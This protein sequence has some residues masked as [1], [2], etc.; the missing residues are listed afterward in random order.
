MLHV[1]NNYRVCVYITAFFWSCILLLEFRRKF[2]IWDSRSIPFVLTLIASEILRRAI[3][4][5]YILR[6]RKVTLV[7]RLMETRIA[8]GFRRWIFESRGHARLLLRLLRDVILV[9]EYGFWRRLRWIQRLTDEGSPLAIKRSREARYKVATCNRRSV[10][11]ARNMRGSTRLRT[12]MP[13]K[14]TQSTELV[15]WSL[16]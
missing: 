1:R 14:N 12:R 10:L 4:G 2:V 16:L 6:A 8:I 11:I 7:E 5:T 9:A 13:K 15:T 3:L